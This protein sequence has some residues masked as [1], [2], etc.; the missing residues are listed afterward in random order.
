MGYPYNAGDAGAA[1]RGGVNR[2][3]MDDRVRPVGQLLQDW[4]GQRCAHKF[5]AW[6]QAGVRMLG[7]TDHRVP[8]RD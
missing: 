5:D 1:R 2:G 3:E 8:G 4:V 6:V 7:Y